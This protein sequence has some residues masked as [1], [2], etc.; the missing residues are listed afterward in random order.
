[1]GHN[2]RGPSRYGAESRRLVDGGATVKERLLLQ[3][4][5]DEAP[6]DG[7]GRR[8]TLAALGIAVGA[9]TIAGSAT[10]A[11]VASRGVALGSAKWLLFGAAS[12]VVAIG[13]VELATKPAAVLPVIATPP[14]NKTFARRVTTASEGPFRP[15]PV[16]SAMPLASS[17][18]ALSLRSAPNP[19]QPNPAQ[20]DARA[21]SA[22]PSEPVA[23]ELR[24][25]SSGVALSPSTPAEAMISPSELVAQVAALDRAR[26]ALHAGRAS[27]SVALLDAFDRSYPRSSLVPEATVVRVSALLGLGQ[28][29]QAIELVRAYCS[30]GRRG[31]YGH[32]LMALVG[33]SETACEGFVPGP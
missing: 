3:A 9:S 30:V 27:E 13:T 31:A 4:G 10:A 25:S 1:M 5:I 18:I 29:A 7:A 2:P 23:A 11:A 6:P 32:R 8:R 22:L 20:R 17:P 16:E 19:A 24:D 28:R 33:L 15:L 21:T 12:A 14:P 26:A